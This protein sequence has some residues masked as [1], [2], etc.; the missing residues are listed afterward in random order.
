MATAVI[1]RG[2]FF[3]LLVL[4]IGGQEVPNEPNE[5][6]DDPISPFNGTDFDQVGHNASLLNTTTETRP[7]CTQTLK[8]FFD[9]SVNNVSYPTYF[10]SFEFEGE[11]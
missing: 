8:N 4:T 6:T 5:V 11:N 10:H 7:K 1:F 9:E 3:L 2:Y